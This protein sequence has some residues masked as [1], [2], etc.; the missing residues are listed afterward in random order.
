MLKWHVLVR[1]RDEHVLRSKADASSSRRRGRQWG[2][3]MGRNGQ[4][5]VEYGKPANA[6][7]GKQTKT[8]KN[9][10]IITY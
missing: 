2:L 10:R 3:K 4:E 1:R 8:K 6:H 7:D 5:K 9:C